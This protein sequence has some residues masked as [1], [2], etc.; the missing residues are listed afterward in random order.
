GQGH[1]GGTR[2]T[3]SY[4]SSAPRSAPGYS[5]SSSGSEW[6]GAG[7]HGGRGR[8]FG[9]I[10]GGLIGSLLL[11]RPWKGGI[12]LLDVMLLSGFIYW[13]FWSLSTLA[14]ARAATARQVTPA[15]SQAVAVAEPAKTED[16]RSDYRRYADMAAHAFLKVQAAWATRNMA[17]TGDLLSPELGQT[18]RRDCE[19]MRADRVINHLK[20]V[21]IA[22]AEVT[23]VRQDVR[24][25]SVTVYLAGSL[26]DYT[27]D[28]RGTVLEGDPV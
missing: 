21:K 3:R 15:P 1:T 11:G 27:T 24:R 10:R 20:D 8:S 25:D 5:G 9:L 26:V 28:E 12:S 6:G 7:G 14:S 18:L 4:A 16:T 17:G 2:G 13:V 22:A 23:T 19:R